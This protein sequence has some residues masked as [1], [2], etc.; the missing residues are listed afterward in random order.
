MSALGAIALT[1]GMRNSLNA[2]SDLDGQIATTNKRLATGKRVN[3][4]LDGPLNYFLAKGFDKNKTDL[5]NLL[6]NQNIALQTL[7]KT[8][9]T[10]ESISKLVE[11]S[12][13]L[14]RQARQSTDAAV[15]TTL[16]NQIGTILRQ[17]NEL[18]RDAG[19]NGRNLLARV[20]DTLR[21]DFNAQT[22]VAQT[23]LTVT[24]VSLR[25]E[26]AGG[27]NFAVAANGIA[28]TAGGTPDEPGTFAVTWGVTAADDAE[29]D[30]F[31]VDAQ[32]GLN[33]LQSQASSFSV[34]LTIL[35][36]RIDYSKGWQ[37]NLATA[38]DALTLADIN[39]EGANLTSLQT[40]QQL[41]VNAL[42]LAS[43]SD[44]A[45]LRLF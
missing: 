3:E 25:A 11:S 31:L 24:G 10:V 12:Q 17:I 34:N 38:S 18:T 1:Q 6:D 44:Q 15:R 21:I 5:L 16:G 43:Q 29:I 7:T 33:Y 4:A 26:A 8:I 28:Y 41:S 2:L 9:K 20:P 32:D 14:A 30:A 45:I 13:A 35:Q 37:R 22:G 36:V 23:N 27:L 42:R 40:R 19:F 39:E